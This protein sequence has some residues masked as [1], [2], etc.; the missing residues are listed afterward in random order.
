MAES[1]ATQ[2]IELINSLG[3]FDV[4]VKFILGFAITFGMLEKTKIFGDN[5][6]KIN[7]LIAAAIG[8]IVVL[9]F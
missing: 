1:V 6:Q 5:M 4:I 7:A 2:S 3:F 8:I 9:S